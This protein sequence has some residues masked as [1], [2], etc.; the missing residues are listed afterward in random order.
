MKF[1]SFDTSLHQRIA[2]FLVIA[3]VAC[4]G[5]QSIPD[6]PTASTGMTAAQRIEGDLSIARLCERHNDV[7][8]ATRIYH[9][10][11]KQ[12]PKNQETLHRLGVIA[13]REGKMTS[14]LTYLESA[15][16]AGEAS[17]ELLGDL[18][19][20]HYQQ[21]RLEQ[22]EDD[23][24]RALDLDG[25]NQRA[26]NNLGLV[27]AA[28]GK[29]DR[30]LALFRQ[31]SSPAEAYANLAYAQTQR[32]DLQ[33]AESNYH[34]ALESEPQT[35]VAAIGLIEL[36]K[37]ARTNRARYGLSNNAMLAQ[38]EPA[39]TRSTTRSMN[40]G[41]S[42]DV[43]ND[44]SHRSANG[45]LASHSSGAPSTDIVDLPAPTAVRPHDTKHIADTI[46]Q[47]LSTPLPPPPTVAHVAAVEEVDAGP[48]IA[49]PGAFD[50][51]SAI[52]AIEPGPQV[53]FSGERDR[54]DGLASVPTHAPM[55][56]SL[57]SQSTQVPPS[58]SPHDAKWTATS[59]ADS[60]MPRDV[61]HHDERVQAVSYEAHLPSRETLASVAVA[62]PS[63]P[64]GTMLSDNAVVPQTVVPQTVATG[65][66]ADP[67]DASRAVVADPAVTQT[68]DWPDP[69]GLTLPPVEQSLSLH[70]GIPSSK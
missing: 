46:V 35:R 37:H 68:F 11:L 63:Q 1:N 54:L 26:L 13:A 28:Q 17:S 9:A 41:R 65:I 30:A 25:R 61:V 10:I 59:G 2:S 24:N 38:Q 45:A 39:V 53:P 18:G 60:R 62:E 20:V 31:V 58:S 52:I 23:L 7:A 6:Q 69:V 3:F 64:I 29:D 40:R 51:A 27:L 15:M 16:A 43:R 56:E 32:G 48:A 70:S 19:Y 33:A 47:P 36:R 44:V 4:A 34:R 50:P 21:D 8:K 55:Q 66:A 5:C 14:A 42:R 57:P 67:S 22:A 49:T 12:D